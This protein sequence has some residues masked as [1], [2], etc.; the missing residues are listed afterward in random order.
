MGLRNGVLKYHKATVEICF[1]EDHICCDLCPLMETYS[2][3]QCRRT[4]EYLFDSR[5]IGYNCPM[6]FENEDDEYAEYGNLE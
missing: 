2:R 3:K 6:K 5:T 4:G 1:P